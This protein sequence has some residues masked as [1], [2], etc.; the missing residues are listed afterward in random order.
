MYELHFN[1]LGLVDSTVLQIRAHKF[2]NTEAL[3]G[4]YENL[5]AIY[6][7]KYGNAQLE[8]LW[9]G[10]SHFDKYS[11]DWNAMCSQW[12]YGLCQ[13]KTF[14]KGILHLTVFNDEF[15]NTFFITNGLKGIVNDYFNL[16][17]LKINGNKRVYLKMPETRKAS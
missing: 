3:G 8:I 15:K 5:A 17:V 7:F 9:D 16:K 4:I 13:N 6:R 2:N 1:P 14:I 12:M 10:R 11:E